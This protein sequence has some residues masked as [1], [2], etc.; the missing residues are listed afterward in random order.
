MGR[1]RRIVLDPEL[2][3]PEALSESV[4]SDQRGQ[5]RF[6]RIARSAVEREEVRVA[7]DAARARLDLPAG[8]CRVEIR[9]VIGDLE[10]AEAL[11]T[12]IAGIEPVLL[13]AFLALERLNCHLAPLRTNLR[14]SD[15]GG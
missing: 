15:V 11:L 14:R 13:A 5:A 12:D 6:E 4:G 8:L 10:R 9:E 2:P 3:E 1:I 7:P